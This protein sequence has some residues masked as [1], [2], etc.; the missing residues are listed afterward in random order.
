MKSFISQGL[1]YYMSAQKILG[2]QVFY[3]L[4]HS[5]FRSVFPEIG[6]IDRIFHQYKEQIHLSSPTPL[7]PIVKFNQE[8]LVIK[9]LIKGCIAS[10]PSLNPFENIYA[11]NAGMLTADTLSR[12]PVNF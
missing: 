11:E 12:N 10:S 8:N 3:S 5:D 7:W 2:I 6:I 1:F 4:L 9:F